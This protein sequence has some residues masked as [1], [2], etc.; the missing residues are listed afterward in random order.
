MH[1]WRHWSI[2]LWFCW[3]GKVS[4]QASWMRG[5]RMSSC[6]AETYLLGA[7]TKMGQLFFNGIKPVAVVFVSMWSHYSKFS[8]DW[9]AFSV[10]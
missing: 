6:W 3:V 2:P 9:Y 1:G 4:G 8:N 7:L 5:R 10:V